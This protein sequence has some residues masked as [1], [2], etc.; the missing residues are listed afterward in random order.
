MLG[1]AIRPV[2][3]LQLRA[4]VLWS[5]RENG[6]RFLAMSRASS[7]WVRR[8]WV[9]YCAVV[10][11]LLSCVASLSPRAFAVCPVPGIRAN[12]EFFARDVV[13]TGKVQTQR[14]DEAD[15]GGWYYH[16]RATK[17]FKGPVQKQFTVYTED[18]DVRFPLRLGRQYLLFADQVDGRLEIDNCGNSALLADAARSLHEIRRIAASKSGKIEGWVAGET[19]GVN[20]VGVHVVVRGGSRV[21]RVLADRDGWFHFRAPAGPYSVDFS[22]GE[23]YLNGADSFWYRPEHFVLHAG[24]TASLQMV[25]VR[26]SRKISKQR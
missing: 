15:V 24:E 16:L 5:F 1:G 12:G 17:V 10:V 22:N 6:R 20:L 14:Y 2:S 26:H 4:G 18:S 3:L 13:F 8:R 23:Y 21:Y 9:R 11:V 25:S 7:I 19:S